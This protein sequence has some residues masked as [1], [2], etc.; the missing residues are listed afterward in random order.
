MSVQTVL[1]FAFMLEDIYDHDEQLTE[2]EYY[3]ALY[4]VLGDIFPQLS[5]TELEKI[6]ERMLERLPAPYAEG[7]LDTVGNIGKKIGTGA[8]KFAADNPALVQAAATSAGAVVGGPVGA[9]LGSNVGNLV[10]QQL[11]GGTLPQAGKTL[12][13]MQNP[14]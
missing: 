2:D 12:A 9:K 5:D 8:L 13:L 7:I 4:Y 11:Q 14:Q 3:D 10:T 1:N 6:L